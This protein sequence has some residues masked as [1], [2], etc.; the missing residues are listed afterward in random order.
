MRIAAQSAH[1]PAA[2]FHVPGSDLG[3]L[4]AKRT[5]GRDD[6]YGVEP[7]T[8]PRVWRFGLPR[9]S[10]R[11]GT[12]P[13]WMAHPRFCE[14]GASIASYLVSRS[15]RDRELRTD[16]ANWNIGDVVDLCF[17][18]EKGMHVH[19]NQIDTNV[20]LYALDAAQKTEAKS[21]ADR[22]RKKLLNAAWALGGDTDGV[23]VR[24]S[25]DDAGEGQ[26]NR[27]SR[28]NRGGEEG[29]DANSGS[30]EDP[31]SGWA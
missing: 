16:L 4:T 17:E 2:M 12:Y 15:E 11:N 5:L 8:L 30:V 25:G 26:A 21:K 27:Q 9:C 31:F 13:A 7:G 1:I 14:F 19:A 18:G 29:G 20:Q 3:C 10:E 23:V 28:E 22:T 24:L 6:G